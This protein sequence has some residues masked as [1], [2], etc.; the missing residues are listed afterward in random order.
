MEQ[1]VKKFTRDRLVK[2]ITMRQF[3]NELT[4]NH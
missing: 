1:L 3:L 2:T 4:P